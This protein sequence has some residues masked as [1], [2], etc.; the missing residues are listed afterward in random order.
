M[1]ALRAIVAFSLAEIAPKTVI[2]ATGDRITARV[3]GALGMS[4]VGAWLAWA[5]RAGAHVQAVILTLGLTGAWLAVTAGRPQWQATMLAMRAT[6]A[7]LGLWLATHVE[8][9]RMAYVIT[10]GMCLMIAEVALSYVVA[11]AGP[12]IAITT[13]GQAFG[14][15]AS[16]VVPAILIMAM[17][18]AWLGHHHRR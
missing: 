15:W 8:N 5:S 11:P 12:G 3:V 7:M 18:W 6:I 17:G 13:I 10:L 4:A 1:I 14:P 9:P 2:A 16:S